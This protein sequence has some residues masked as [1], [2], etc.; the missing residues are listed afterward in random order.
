MTMKY[1]KAKAKKEELVELVGLQD[2][3]EQA[4][5]DVERLVD[6]CKSVTIKWAFHAIEVK[7][8]DGDTGV[9]IYIPGIS[10]EDL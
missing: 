1:I 5:D 6:A 7:D 10:A 9:L 3:L 4:D 2:I 8:D